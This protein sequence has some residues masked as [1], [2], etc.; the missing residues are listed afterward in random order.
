V[1]AALG[2]SK[3]AHVIT[4]DLG[5]STICSAAEVRFEGIELEEARALLREREPRGG[6][7]FPCR[8]GAVSDES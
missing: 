5:Q 1:I 8:V 3:I 6:R 4:G 2:L 7:T